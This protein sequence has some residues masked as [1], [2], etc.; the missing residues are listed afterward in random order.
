[1]TV[2]PDGARAVS[3]SSDNTPRAW[4]LNTGKQIAQLA[5][6]A[7]VETVAIHAGPPLTVVAG[8]AAGSVYCFELR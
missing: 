7:N 6:D 8:D 4:N 5:L 3:G 1:M 2:T